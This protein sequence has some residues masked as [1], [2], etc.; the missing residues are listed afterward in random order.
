[1][2]TKRFSLVAAL[3]VAAVSA[4]A[5][6]AHALTMDQLINGQTLTVGNTTFSN[7]VYAVNSNTPP[8]S[9]VTVST[10]T[11]G[12]ET[13][14]TF[15]LTSGTWTGGKQSVISYDVTTLAPISA[16]KLNFVAT[17]SAGNIAL[18]GETVDN[19]EV[20]VSDPHRSMTLATQVGAGVFTDGAGPLADQLSLTNSLFAATNHIH[21][22]K[23]IDTVGTGSITSVTNGYVTV[24]EPA[25]LG[26]LSVAGLGLLAR[27]RR[28]AR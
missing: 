22:V 8:A 11:S 12:G 23:S 20:P 25:S 2:N 4:V 6:Q 16:V 10:S 21:V 14:I 28:A 3:A 17:G 13:D 9:N 5:S 18:T 7:F 26:I 24:P 19:L 15:S 1:M 27:R